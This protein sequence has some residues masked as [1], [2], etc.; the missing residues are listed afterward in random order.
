MEDYC[1]FAA[2][3]AA[4][5]NLGKIIYVKIKE[6]WTYGWV[7]SA[8]CTNSRIACVLFYA[9]FCCQAGSGKRCTE[10]YKGD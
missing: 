6:D 8:S 10:K 2:I 3:I 7:R 5:G 9:S 1:G 4:V